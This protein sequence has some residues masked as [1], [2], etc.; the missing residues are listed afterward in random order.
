MAR[1]QPD[2]W[3]A[4]HLR[5]RDLACKCGRPECGYKDL[6]DAC[7]ER[8][9]LFF[10]RV[11]E[12]LKE[13]GL[14]FTVNSA[15]RCPAHNAEVGGS[16]NSAHIY[17]V[18]IDIGTEDAPGDLYALAELT[19][20]FSG[21]IWY[22]WGVH[23]D[24]HPNDRVVRG[25]SLGPMEHHLIRLGNRDGLPVETVYAWN[26]DYTIEKPDYILDAEQRM[27]P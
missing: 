16:P 23:L 19:G 8:S 25:Y 20:F 6:D 11:G 27:L 3:V 24:L 15:L 22:P 10:W 17:S 2:Q 7:H 26:C 14:K 5:M 18:A 13:F 21:I 9:V 1:Y 4:P 12:L